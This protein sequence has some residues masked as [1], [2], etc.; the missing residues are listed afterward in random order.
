MRGRP[1]KIKSE[2]IYLIPALIILFLVTIYPLIFSLYM[3]FHRFLTIDPYNRQFIG[4]DNYI[5]L[6]SNPDF[7]H[8][9]R[10]TLI[11]VFATVTLTFFTG[12]GLALLLNQDIKG[13]SI[14]RPIII[15]PIT[16][17]PVV[18]G[19]AWKYLLDRGQGLLGAFLL[20]L[21][22]ISPPAILGDPINALIA[23][24]LADVWAKTPIVLL[25]I[26]AG[27]QGIPQ[28]LL[29]QARIDG[30]D[31]LMRFRVVTLPIIRPLILVAI[32]MKFIDS[33]SAFDQI[34]VMTSGGP[35]IATMTL[36]VLGVRIGFQFY[37]LGQAVAVGILMLIMSGIA[38]AL[39]IRYLLGER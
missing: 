14:V 29:K 25:I 20:P 9:F 23:V 35:G 8:S 31:R 12:L 26:I 1:S 6:F 4:L 30:A 34:Y 19:F 39:L 32:M 11:Y 16:I 13:L 38:I 28:D 24:I 15:L 33:M 10:T 27:L 7:L 3:S 17:A 37:N 21:I 18:V 5:A 2:Y 36:A 22:G